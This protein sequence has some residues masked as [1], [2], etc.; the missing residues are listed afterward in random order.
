MGDGIPGG[1]QHC[2]KMC[3]EKC[4]R[5]GRWACMIWGWFHREDVVSK[6]VDLYMTEHQKSSLL[7]Y[8]LIIRLVNYNVT[9]SPIYKNNIYQ[10]YLRVLEYSS[11]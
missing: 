1:L 8:S 11:K 4:G 3:C 9:T 10:R 5:R 7:E 6:Q 2:H